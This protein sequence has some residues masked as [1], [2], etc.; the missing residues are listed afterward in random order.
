MPAYSHVPTGSYSTPTNPQNPYQTVMNPRP[1]VQVN[2]QPSSSYTP[3][4]I[5]VPFVP[6]RA[7]GPA[8]VPLPQA[9]LVESTTEKVAEELEE[10]G[11]IIGGTSW[12]FILLI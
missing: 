8:Y 2:V 12:I 5:Q 6:P 9:I 10:S 11:S 4:S 7:V 1:Q 3:G